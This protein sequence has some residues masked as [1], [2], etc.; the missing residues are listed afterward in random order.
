MLGLCIPGMDTN[1]RYSN[2]LP[3]YHARSIQT[4]IP[5]SGISALYLD[6]RLGLY[7][8]QDTNIRYSNRV[9]LDTN[10]SNSKPI[11]YT[12]L[13][14]NINLYLYLKIR[15]LYRPYNPIPGYQDM[16]CRYQY[17]VFYRVFF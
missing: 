16:T 7:T 12:Y 10:I 5:I 2:P 11:P 4:W 1:I 13:D 9:Y 17:Q 8:D 15:L 6:I 14:T 3:G